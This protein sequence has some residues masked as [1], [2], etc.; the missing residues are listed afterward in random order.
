MKINLLQPTLEA[1]GVKM[2]AVGLEQLGADEFVERGF[3]DGG[4]G[5][6]GR[7]EGMEVFKPLGERIPCRENSRREGEGEGEGEEGRAIAMAEIAC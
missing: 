7:S 1:H 3:F 4:E 5:T 6:G 2:V